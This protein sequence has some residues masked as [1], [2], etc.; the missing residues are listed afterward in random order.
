MAQHVHHLIKAGRRVDTLEKLS[1]EFVDICSCAKLE[2]RVGPR[3][4]VP[5]LCLHTHKRASRVPKSM[6]EPGP[7]CTR[8]RHD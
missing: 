3:R 5:H 2:G 4:T 7:K 6:N 8:G 1:R